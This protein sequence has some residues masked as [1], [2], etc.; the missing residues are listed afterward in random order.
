M[1]KVLLYTI[2]SI[3]FV[4]GCVQQLVDN[5]PIVNETSSSQTVSYYI[6][7]LPPEVDTKYL[8]VV[9]EATAEWERANPQINFMET[10]SGTAQ[11]LVQWIKEFGGHPIGQARTDLVQ[12]GLGD[13]LCLGKWQPFIYQTVLHIATHEFGHVLGLQ[14][15]DDP[16]NVMYPILITQ[17]ETDVDERR[18]LP[19]DSYSFFPVCTRKSSGLYSIEITSDESIDV[20]V[21]PSKSDYDALVAGNQFNHYPECRG[22]SIRSYQKTCTIPQG[23]GVV[24]SNP[25]FFG[26]IGSDALY[27]I[28]MREL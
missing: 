27:T 6:D 22:E 19:D 11:V 2:I 8:N 13:S 12:I 5:Q 14:H 18:F 10:S 17:Y 4:S 1:R 7:S 9:R 15:S 25:S 16:N 24:L 20:Y 26:V 21:V 28:K 23:G 3:V